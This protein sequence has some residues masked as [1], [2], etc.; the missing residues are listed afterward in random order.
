LALILSL[1]R[2]NPIADDFVLYN[3]PHFDFTINDFNDG[4]LRL[5]YVANN[6]AAGKLNAPP[7]LDHYTES[8]K[9]GE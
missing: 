8:H 4:S 5:K 7:T 2:D 6:R 9:I 3:T 1:V